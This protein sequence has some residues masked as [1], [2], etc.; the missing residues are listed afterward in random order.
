MK[1]NDKMWDWVLGVEGAGNVRLF[2]SASL[3]SL[4]FILVYIISRCILVFLYVLY[5]GYVISSPEQMTHRRVILTVN[6]HILSVFLTW[7]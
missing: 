7:I 3:L 6:N 5:G 2:V 1:W 4:V